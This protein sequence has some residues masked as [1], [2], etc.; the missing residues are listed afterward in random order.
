MGKKKS[1]QVRQRKPT[2]RFSPADYSTPDRIQRDQSNESDPNEVGTVQEVEV[3]SHE[4]PTNLDGNIAT[5]SIDPNV[6]SHEETF[7]TIDEATMTNLGSHRSRTNPPKDN[8]A[9]VDTTVAN[10]IEQQDLMLK[11]QQEVISQQQIMIT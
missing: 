4:E 1:R 8:T 10:L 3:I 11:Q 7:I 5:K 9:A 6:S 2:C